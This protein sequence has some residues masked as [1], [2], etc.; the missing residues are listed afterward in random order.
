MKATELRGKSTDELNKLLG[1]TRQALLESKRALAAGELPNPRVVA[2]N[3][4]D[5]ARI[6]TILSEK[7][8][9]TSK[10]EA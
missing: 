6:Q 5:I 2:K 8:T 3:R 1:E 4:R 9:N 10:G 7:S